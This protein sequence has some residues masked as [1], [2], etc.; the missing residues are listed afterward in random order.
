MDEI[1]RLV[2][3]Y[4]D[5]LDGFYEEHDTKPGREEA[6]YE[7][8]KQSCSPRV[9]WQPPA[10]TLPEKHAARPVEIAVIGS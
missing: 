1:R 7:D 8:G 6:A 4:P 9:E 5:G 2:D 3:K 10:I